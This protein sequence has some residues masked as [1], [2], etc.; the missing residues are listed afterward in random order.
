MSTNARTELSGFLTR[1]HRFYTLHVAGRMAAVALGVLC[2]V[3][4]LV[5]PLE[6]FVGAPVALRVGLWVLAGV[7]L[8]WGVYLL[9]RT[10]SDRSHTRTQAIALE[11]YAPELREQ[12]ITAVDTDGPEA[13][14]L[15][16]ADWLLDHTARQARERAGRLDLRG[17]YRQAGMLRALA[18]FGGALAVTVLLGLVF[19]RPASRTLEALA[20]P[21]QDMPRPVPFE[22][23]VD[24]EES[25][26]LQYESV[27]L[28]ATVTGSRLP[29]MAL[30]MWRYGT[31][32]EP[33][34]QELA[35]L[36]GHRFEHTLSS[37]PRSVE[38][39]FAADG[40]TSEVHTVQVN[41]RP[42]LVSLSGDCRPPR[43]TNA[44]AFPLSGASRRWVV[45]EGSQ[46]EITA[47]SDRK[48]ASG[49]VLFADSS[50]A[51]LEISGT[52]AVARFGA[53]GKRTLRVFV[54]DSAGFT[55]FD[56]VPVQLE[57]IP[58]LAPQIALLEPRGDR[59]IP[60][61]MT[62]PVVV[63]LLDDY[64][65]S[66]LEVRHQVEGE[67]GSG[68]VLTREL[69]LP[70]GFG[71]EGTFRFDWSVN[72]LR[73]FPGDRVL[74][75]V[76]VYDN[77]QPSALWAETPTFVLRLP[78]IEEIIAETE[79]NQERRTDDV[80]EA[81]EKQRG[82]SEE[83]REM[84][85]EMTGQDQVEWE[86]R[87][88]LEQ[89]MATQEQ[90]A[91]ELQEWADELEKEAESLADNRMA[92]LE[93][94]QKM[95]EIARLLEEVMTPELKE[96]MERLQKAMEAM[97]PEEM[98]QAL[99][100]FQ[101]NQEEL[102]QQME[103]TLAQLRQMQVEQMMENMLRQA[104]ELAQNQEAQNRA[105]ESASQHTLDS[106]ARQE[107]ALRSQMQELQQKAAKLSELNKQNR[108]NPDVEEFSQLVQSSEAGQD[109][110]Q[111]AQDMQSGQKQQ[112]STSGQSASARLRQ[113]VSGMQQK[114][115]ELANEMNAEQLAA[116]RDL[117]R[118]TLSLSEE[119][120]QLGDSA[121]AVSHSSLA[122]RE[123][124][125]QQS[126]MKGSIGRLLEDFNQQAQ[127]NL[128]LSPDVR[129]HLAESGR[130][131]E[132]ATGTLADR[133]GPAAS[134][135]QYETMFSL[136]EASKSLMESMDNQSQCQ[137]GSEGQGKMNQGM[138][139]M[140]QQQLKLNEASQAMR[141][142]YGLSPGEQEAVKRLAGQQGS[143]Q[144]SMRDL[145]SQTMAGRDRLGRL[146][147]MAKSMDEVV[148]DMQ[149]GE[150]TDE[151]LERQ[152]NIY[153]R[154][155]DFQKSLQRQDFENRRQ[156]EAADVLVGRRPDQSS[157]EQGQDF[158]QVD[159][160]RFQN[161][162]YPP[163]FRALVKEYFEAVSR[164]AGPKE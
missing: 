39:W 94:L 153:N 127:Q 163:G 38:Y 110:D 67:G 44:A 70:A 68:E 16:Y 139:N 157:E 93:M 84:A 143:I 102:L 50:Q 79:Q 134:M 1:V 92:S 51:A 144:S 90:L 85:R 3:F 65:L 113:M 57:I 103:R 122:L 114:M 154:M 112:A 95:N 152:R 88:E 49:Y 72:G 20:N 61:N 24:S 141:N 27:Q 80:A 5:V 140:S 48:L 23:Q 145:A 86:N 29:A 83:L 58:D 132:A 63:A 137:G 150:L 42:E 125:A 4:W 142:P 108:A 15:G 78:S 129:R 133:N 53:S 158:R 156:S 9:W 149:R 22:W 96:A 8:A 109:M 106:L 91:E 160:N 32:G 35:A 89:A 36:P 164:G 74:Y 82:L 77:R 120:E 6:H 17:F 123:M 98:K 117:T 136:N 37:V 40:Q 71:R 97:S 135:L 11:Q 55:N 146:E 138:Q 155:L 119:Q 64:G 111:M 12:L 62:V 147:E 60:E 14:K 31:D 18:W 7:A 100:D 43:Y 10:L 26:I 69:A 118:R 13:R 101:M 131:A 59:D 45:P 124:A 159:W 56:P 81:V 33:F 162:W 161:E 21:T 121:R 30:L 25:R 54:S 104:E 47:R 75:S 130:K 34:S 128:F 73:L 46:I 2:G 148:E 52:E 126:A 99:E 107:E 115:D 151:T 41:T 116:L 76:R 87:Q 19:P 105:V 66:R 28:K